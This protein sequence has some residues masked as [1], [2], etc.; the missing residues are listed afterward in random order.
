MLFRS[1][2]QGLTSNGASKTDIHDY[3]QNAINQVNAD[4]KKSLDEPVYS[5]LDVG[6]I[7][8][9]LNQLKDTYLYPSSETGVMSVAQKHDLLN[10]IKVKLRV[11]NSNDNAT[12]A[13]ARIQQLEDFGKK[14]I[15]NK[16][17][18]ANNIVPFQ[19]RAR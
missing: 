11:L 7:L 9:Y 19:R 16:R 6:I 15:F 18:G 17:G 3:L 2:L 12:A 14:I 13:L 5:S 10:K 8:N 1:E 4:I